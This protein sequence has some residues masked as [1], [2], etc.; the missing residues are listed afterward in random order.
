MIISYICV[1]GSYLEYLA[2][3]SLSQGTFR[4]GIGWTGNYPWVLWAIEWG[5][6]LALVLDAHARG[7]Q[8]KEANPPAELTIISYICVVGSYLEYLAFAFLSQGSFRSSIG[9]TGNHP[10]VLWAIEQGMLLAL[11]LETY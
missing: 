9:W 1:A 3:A 10:W 2:F 6:L 8:A 7:I 11:V 4:S 5:M